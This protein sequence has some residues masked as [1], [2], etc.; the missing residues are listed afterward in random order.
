MLQNSATPKTN[1][2][3]HSN[4]KKKEDIQ[5]PPVLTQ[6][7]SSSATRSSSNRPELPKEYKTVEELEASMQKP[8]S[9]EDMPTSKQFG[10]FGGGSRTATH[11]TPQVVTDP[12]PMIK[13]KQ[14]MT[15][16]NKL[17]D[18]M[19]VTGE[20]DKSIPKMPE[21]TN[22]QTPAQA[23]KSHVPV[24]ITQT[25][26]MSGSPSPLP[27]GL[28]Q[29]IS[30]V[31]AA[32]ITQ[33]SPISPA[34]VSNTHP[35]LMQ[36]K[37]GMP[38]I[39][40]C[41]PSQAN[42]AGLFSGPL[43]FT[44]PDTSST[45]PRICQSTFTANHSPETKA[46]FT[47]HVWNSAPCTYCAPA[48]HSP[49]G[50]KSVSAD[51]ESSLTSAAVNSGANLPPPNQV[52]EQP[53]NNHVPTPKQQN[54]THSTAVPSMAFTPTSV[55]RKLANDKVDERHRGNASPLEPYNSVR[56]RAIHTPR[57]S[58][59]HRMQLRHDMGPAESTATAAA[60]EHEADCQKKQYN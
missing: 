44:M 41:L 9:A 10:Q 12:E 1:I 13:P 53:A 32:S 21:V 17:V 6:L 22:A 8:V 40:R 43:S 7:L 47:Y 31:Q 34:L 46:A 59:S 60:N 57:D 28:T 33:Q 42:M 3:E 36:M 37:N 5:L 11:S 14:E 58:S 18:L 26:G 2:D 20:L 54:T 38:L 50:T 25:N 29:H 39:W 30:R 48:L 15:A 27:P 55:I 19:K 23:N 45:I 52:P 24:D 35:P 16:F 51:D 49:H 56:D 4:G